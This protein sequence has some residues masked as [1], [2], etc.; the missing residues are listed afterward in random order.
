MAP[1]LTSCLKDACTL[2]TSTRKAFPLL[3]PALFMHQ[4]FPFHPSP[5][6][7]S[8]TPYCPLESTT[9]TN[10]CSTAPYQLWQQL[11]V[12]SLPV[13]RRLINV[14]VLLPL[15]PVIHSSG[16]ECVCVKAPSPA[17]VERSPGTEG[18]NPARCSW[19]GNQISCSEVAVSKSPTKV[20]SQ[21]TKH[22]AVEKG[23]RDLNTR[24]NGSD[25]LQESLAHQ[26]QKQS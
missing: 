11:M 18:E 24:K 20:S 25:T 16:S 1:R 22:C 12:I 7:V 15:H 19:S 23:R 8:S 5:L 14:F 17:K 10:P 13:A 21:Q 6:N 2:P 3:I 4:A 9:E 26:K